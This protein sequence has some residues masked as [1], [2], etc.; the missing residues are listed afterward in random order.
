MMLQKCCCF[1][2]RQ[3]KPK[4]NTIGRTSYLLA[5]KL[6]SDI[7]HLC[8]KPSVIIWDVALNDVGNCLQLLWV[9]VFHEEES[10]IFFVADY[11][12]C[13]YS[14]KSFSNTWLESFVFFVDLSKLFLSVV[15]DNIIDVDVC[16]FK[17]GFSF[18]RVGMVTHFYL[19]TLN[20]YLFRLRVLYLLF[21][22]CYW[23]STSLLF[24]S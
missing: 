9:E 13:L 19:F 21:F 15:L 12:K 3:T 1:F 14:S 6:H 11:L 10:T 16:G 7:F 17:K 18:L 4:I 23:G 22:S 2:R 5:N 8:H 24:Y 20:L